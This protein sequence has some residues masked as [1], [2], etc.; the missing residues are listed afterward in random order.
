MNFIKKAGILTTTFVMVSTLA[1]P[2]ANEKVNIKTGICITSFCF[3]FFPSRRC[4]DSFI[5]DPCFN[6]Y[7][8]I[9]YR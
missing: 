2:V 3:Y 8:F 7:F 9:S 1:L 5:L 4:F 6:V